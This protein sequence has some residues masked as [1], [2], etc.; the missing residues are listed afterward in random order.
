MSRLFRSLCCIC[1]VFV[2]GCGDEKDTTSNPPVA[3]AGSAETPASAPA[4]DGITVDSGNAGQS[5][6]DTTV[7]PVEQIMEEV[8]SGKREVSLMTKVETSDPVRVRGVIAE[9][10]PYQADLIE[11]TA[12]P[13]VKL[14]SGFLDLDYSMYIAI[15][16]DDILIDC[17]FANQKDLKGLKIGQTIELS[18]LVSW[19]FSFNGPKSFKLERCNLLNAEPAEIASMPFYSFETSVQDYGDDGKKLEELKSKLYDAGISTLS[20]T[21]SHNMFY[22]VELYN[23]AAEADGHLPKKTIQVLNEIPMISK[24]DLD[25]YGAISD[26][27]ARDLQQVRYCPELQVGAKKISGAGLAALLQIPGVT[28]LHLREPQ[29]LIPED[30][31]ALQHVPLLRKLE[32]SGSHDEPTFDGKADEALA[33]LK[34]TPELRNLK[35]WT[36]S[37][38]DDGLTVLAKLPH[39]RS[40]DLSQCD[41]AGGGLKHLDGAEDFWTLK[42]DGEA[43]NDDLADSLAVLKHLIVL[44]LNCPSV[45]SRIGSAFSN[46]PKLQLLSISKAQLDNSFAASLAQLPALERLT[47]SYSEIGDDFK[48]PVSA[49]PHLKQIALQSTGIGGNVCEI[50]ATSPSLESIDISDNPVDDDAIARLVKSANQSKLEDIVLDN[51][52]VS[53]Q[54]L[55]QLAKLSS[56]EAITVSDTLKV[57]D[58]TKNILKAA[59]ITLNLR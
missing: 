5:P 15:A 38:T 56:L 52:A 22:D 40:L 43:V 50:L 2:V 17:E 8:Q 1:V 9:I 25:S 23:S 18:G 41:V 3:P 14:E 32:I 10:D 59:K 44:E 36:L 11:E 47:L 46:L 6:T 28:R 30:L 45:T 51:T 53:E 42:L 4:R 21:F 55:V 57:S 20:K 39:L 12:K 49:L 26:T 58:E 54:S 37:I 19:S 34:Y 27:I 35:L 24:L 16:Q 48:L 33:R 29:M 7:Y 13:T 31:E